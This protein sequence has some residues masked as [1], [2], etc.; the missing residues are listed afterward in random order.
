MTLISRQVIFHRSSLHSPISTRV[1]GPTGECPGSHADSNESGGPNHIQ[2]FPI[3]MQAPQT[4]AEHKIARDS[5]S[6]AHTAKV[7]DKKEKERLRHQ[8]NRDKKKVEKVAAAA[9]LLQLNPPLPQAGLQL[10]S[11]LS[12]SRPFRCPHPSSLNPSLPQLI[13]QSLARQKR[14]SRSW[15]LS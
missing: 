14:R 3:I 7:A 15:L 5:T 13:R 2:T 12:E 9:A 11:L 8:A 1:Q 4:A 10:R 6:A